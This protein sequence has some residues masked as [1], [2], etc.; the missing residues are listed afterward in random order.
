MRLKEIKPGMVIHC[1]TEDEAK[2]LSEYGG[3][4]DNFVEYWS[5]NYKENTCYHLKCGSG[6]Y[7]GNEQ[8]YSNKGQEITPFTSLIIEE[9][10]YEDGLNEAWEAAK[11]IVL[12]KEHG[13]LPCEDLE[14]IFEREPEREVEYSVFKSLTP[15]EVISRLKFYKHE[16][17]MR[18]NIKVG[19][20]VEHI[21]ESN[22]KILVTAVYKDSFDGIKVGQSDE[23]GKIGGCYSGSCFGDFERTGTNI[24]ISSI[25]AEIGKE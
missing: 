8:Y 13:G 23:C 7:F 6:W 17:N 16:K 22:V 3:M 25:L 5:K 14:R 19:D 15:Q 9:K 20:V 4:P 21:R 2:L 18:E 12:R 11:K 1:K 24:D 10:T